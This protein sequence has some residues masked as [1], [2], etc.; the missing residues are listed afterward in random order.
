LSSYTSEYPHPEINKGCGK[1]MK[2]GTERKG[3]THRAIHTI[4]IV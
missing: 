2:K 3:T 4:I 1:E